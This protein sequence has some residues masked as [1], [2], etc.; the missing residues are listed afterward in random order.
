MLLNSKYK[1]VKIFYFLDSEFRAKRKFILK[2]KCINIIINYQQTTKTIFKVVFNI[3]I[4]GDNNK[5]EVMF[6]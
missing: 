1:T 4:K 6:Y 5:N 3:Y 2:L